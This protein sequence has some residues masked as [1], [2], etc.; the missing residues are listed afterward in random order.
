MVE[1]SGSPSHGSTGGHPQPQHAAYTSQ[2]R[3][4]LKARIRLVLWILPI[5]ALIVAVWG[6]SSRLMARSELSKR[7]QQEARITVVT[8]KAQ[9]SG[10][11]EELVLPGVVQAYIEAPI[12][13][14]TSGY[15]RRWY[16]DIGAHVKKGELLAEID[17]PEV[18]RQLSQARAD[19]NT[20]Q[21]NLALSRTTNDRWKALLA[22]QSV[23]QQDADEKAGDA[24]AKQAMEQSAAQNVARLNDLESFKRVLAPFDGVV[25]ARNTDIGALINA[26]QAAGSELFEVADTEELRIYAQVP[27]AYAATITAGLQTE[28]HFTEHPGKSYPAE[29]VRTSNALDPTARTL[30]VELHLDNKDGEIFPGAYAEVHFKL[31]S[32]TQTLRLPAN[33]VLFRA[34]GLQVATVGGDNRIKLKSILQGRDFGKTIEVLDGIT[35]DDVVVVN[36]PDSITDGVAVTIAPPPQQRDGGKLGQQPQAKQAGGNKT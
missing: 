33:T 35:R 17:T 8:V 30:Q 6:V 15:L 32:S 4:Q 29:A 20:A 14:R 27:E 26:G 2:Q 3:D 5:L 24:A 13:A 28:L 25:T 16:T 1:Q 21:A 12:Y 11:G 31:P 18:D 23:S 19:L 10:A 7:S 34:P 22:T 9:L 36:P